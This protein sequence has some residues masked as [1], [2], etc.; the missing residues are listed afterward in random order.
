MA[1]QLS[2]QKV[3]SYFLSSPTSLKLVG[4][5]CSGLWHLISFSPTKIPEQISLLG[6]NNS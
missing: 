4:V 1:K 3:A 2:C 6:E 5:L